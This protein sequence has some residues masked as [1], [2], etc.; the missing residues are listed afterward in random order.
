ML[1]RSLKGIWFH[2]M[3]YDRRTI[4]HTNLTNIWESW[5]SFRVYYKWSYNENT[6]NN[7]NK[8]SNI[9]TSPKELDSIETWLFSYIFL[10]KSPPLSLSVSLFTSF[11]ALHILLFPFYEIS[12]LSTVIPS[13]VIMYVTK[14]IIAQ[15]ILN[16]FFN[17]ISYYILGRNVIN[18]FNK[19]TY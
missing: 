6:N 1:L 11:S 3:Y 9:T 4:I 10:C 14:G 12:S 16:R 13:Y 18:N 2:E 17:S 15:L 8:N 19:L 7:D 5:W